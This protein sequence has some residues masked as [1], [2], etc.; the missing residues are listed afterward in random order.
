MASPVQLYQREMH[1]NMGFF[2]TWLPSSAIELG[3]IGV[4]EAGR[5]R[6]IGSLKELGIVDVDV[7][8]G[9]PENVSYSASA[10]RSSGISAGAATAVP[11]VSGEVS[12]EFASEGGYVFEAM[13]MRQMEISDRMA[14]AAALLQ[15]YKKGAWQAEWLVVDTVYTAHSATVLVSQ[16][17]VSKIVLKA[18]A[19]TLPL[20]TLL[21]ADPNL[22]L[23]VASSSGRIVHVI[24][25]DNLRPLYSCVKVRDPLLGRPSVVPV[26]GEDDRGISPLRRPGI[27]DLLNS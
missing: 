6:R 17:T 7:R 20:G 22:G 5:F 3:D 13:A 15:S 11:V 18:S 25:A 16:D 9:A 14:L 8:E 27:D 1:K 21:L 4:L 23:T 10:K 26:R 12:I 24:A 19:A 2:A